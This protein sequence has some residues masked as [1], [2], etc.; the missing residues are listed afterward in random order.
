MAGLVVGAKDGRLRGGVENAVVTL[1]NGYLQHPAN[2][3]LRSMVSTGEISESGLY[4]VLQ[5]LAF[6]LLLDQATTQAGALSSLGGFFWSD[7]VV[8]PLSDA[9]ISDDWFE[10]AVRELPGE[11]GAEELGSV[12]ESLLEL[13]LGIEMDPWVLTLGPSEQHERKATGSYYTPTALVENLLDC[14]LDPAINSA[15]SAEDPENRLLDLMILDP[16]CGS[17]YFLVAAARRL[18]SALAR[19]R[20][21][22]R[23]PADDEIELAVREVVEKCIFGVDIDPIAVELCKIALWSCAGSKGMPVSGVRCGNS[24]LGRTPKLL[25]DGKFN[26]TDSGK[27]R[28][29]DWH[30]EFP[31][32]FQGGQANPSTGWFGGFDV[33]VGNPPFLNQLE[34]TTAQ[35]KKHAAFL[36]HRYPGV[37]KGYADIATVFAE[38]SSQLVRPEGG[39]VGLVQPGSILASGDAIGARQALTD[40]GTLET[41]WIAGEKVFNASVLTCALVFRNGRHHETQELRRYKGLDFHDL[42]M[43]PISTDEIRHMDTW[44]PL[45]A[46][47]FGIPRVDL[48][49][50]RTMGEV[51]AATADFR[52][53]FYGLAPFV[54]EA[55]GRVPDGVS[56]AALVTTGLIDPADL[57]WGKRPTKFNKTS[58]KAPVVDLNRLRTDGDL[59]DWA[60]SRLVPKLLLATQTRAIEVV[61]DQLGVL[62]PSVPVITVTTDGISL[63]H[64]AAA[65]MS[66]PI[67]AWAAARYLGAALSIDAV[68]LSASQV[69]GLPLPPASA[70]WD[71][72][73]ELVCDASVS[74]SP[75][76]RRARLVEA[77]E[78]MC[79]AYGIL[80]ADELMTWWRNRLPK[81][82]SL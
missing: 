44:A 37:A 75:E 14:T 20:S 59:G 68:K 3:G 60:A 24:L 15:L 29:F 27:D 50:S 2:T 34:T 23:H 18:G 22:Q 81:E 48:D 40:R 73:A 55:D 31:E 11:I 5:C 52:D 9:T 41:L 45:I 35:S 16:A 69:H 62:L 77:G 82:H 76:L 54:K 64:T 33:I 13:E 80:E 1:G 12:Y 30:L 57:L 21:T 63:W 19:Q 32:V 79:N 6:R 72:G 7:E 47:G 28:W 65:L 36:K 42:G 46:D 43:L 8:G 4:R 61:V 49:Q 67:T 71:R 38:L 58:Y 10:E 78:V 53:Q 66:P 26:E 51:L 74:T 25:T 39:R 70:A 56:S 17:G